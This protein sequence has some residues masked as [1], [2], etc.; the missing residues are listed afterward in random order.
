M[1]VYDPT[2][3]ERY[4]TALFN[5]SKRTGEQAAVLADAEELLKLF[6]PK[7]KIRLFVES[8]Q[9]TTEAK[10]EL[11]EKSLKGK[12]H[13]LLYHL[14]GL[15]LAK[16]R[17]EYVTTILD[18]FRVLVEH[19]QGIYE[20]QVATASSLG[21]AEKNKLQSALEAFTKAKLKIRYHVD[22][23]L[24]GGVRFH[25]GDVLIDDTLKGKLAKISHSLHGAISGR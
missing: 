7:S 11:L 22:P 9:V 20:A 17:I 13:N 21:D 19:E 23:S 15:L 5:V 10:E 8:P 25:Y 3:S 18:R 1:I 16:G 12:L 4:A 2:V 6:A 24:I 14:L